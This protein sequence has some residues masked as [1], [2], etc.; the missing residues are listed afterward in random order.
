MVK[1]LKT[2]FIPISQIKPYGSVEGR[3]KH[4]QNLM[5]EFY[6]N[7]KDE[8]SSHDVPL[9][10]VKKAYLKVLPSHKRIE[11]QKIKRGANIGGQVNIGINEKGNIAGY[12]VNLK[13]NY[14]G[15]VQGLGLQEFGTLMH[16]TDHLFSYFTNPKYIQ[17]IITMTEKGYRNKKYFQFFD[18]ELQSTKKQ[19]RKD[20]ATVLHK[21]LEN[22]F[23]NKSSDEKINTLQDFRYRLL[24]EKNAYNTGNSYQTAIED[25]HPG[26][27]SLKTEPLPVWK[28]HFD[29]K[30]KVISDMLKEALQSERKKLMQ[31]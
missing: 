4:T 15:A 13:P 24:N 31:T 17:R 11:V 12:I 22:Y 2:A 3:Y 14:Y 27:L 1:I 29:E 30:L 25:Y 7:I 18:K 6:N 21:K 10:N 16:E 5:A 19:N 20:F 8:F 28:F 23:K 9:K 26:V